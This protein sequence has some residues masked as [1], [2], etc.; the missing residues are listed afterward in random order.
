VVKVKQNGRIANCSIYLAIGVNRQGRKEVLGIWAGEN[1][2]AKFW[3][4]VVT[5]LKNRGVQDVLI[6]CVDGLKGFPE[7]IESVFPQTQVRL[8]VAHLL[9]NSLG[10]VSWKERKAVAAAL[11]PV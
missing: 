6:A 7:A 2:G 1:E 10:H 4:S 5:E 9:R 8:R 11:K 3:L